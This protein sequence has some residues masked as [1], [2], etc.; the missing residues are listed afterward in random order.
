MYPAAKSCLLPFKTRA[1]THIAHPHS[2][3][4]EPA[5]YESKIDLALTSAK[6]QSSAT[7]YKIARNVFS[8]LVTFRISSVKYK[9]AMVSLLTNLLIRVDYHIAYL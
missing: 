4:A 3:P 8:F 7:E 9:S 1:N 6:F 5:L 2:Q